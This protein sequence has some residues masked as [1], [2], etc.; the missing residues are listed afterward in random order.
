[1]VKFDAE[2]RQIRSMADGTYNLVLNIP[3]YCLPQTQTMM[4]WLK[5]QVDVAV[6]YSITE[7]E[8][9]IKKDDNWKW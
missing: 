6:V 5:G 1:V 7:H 4:A 3:E 9:T 2:L 8:N